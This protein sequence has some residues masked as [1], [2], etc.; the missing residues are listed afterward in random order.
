ML[1]GLDFIG[2]PIIYIITYV[3]LLSA[4][5]ILFLFLEH[6]RD[7]SAPIPKK[8]PKV[9]IIIPVYNGAKYIKDCLKSVKKLNYP[10]EKLEIVVVDD[11]STDNSYKEAKKFQ[12][13]KVLKKK[14]SGKAASV[15]HGLERAKGEIIG[16]LDCDSIVSKDALKKMVGYFNEKNVAAVVSGRKA[17][18][19][20]GLLE[21]FQEIEY[22]L[23]LFFWKNYSFVKGLFITPGVLSLYRKKVV[24]KIGKFQDNIT[25]DLEIALRIL[26]RD[27]SVK[28]ALEASTYT[29]VPHKFKDLTKQRVRWNYGLLSNLKNYSFLFSRKYKELGLFILP[30]TLLVN[31]LLVIFFTYIVVTF[32]FHWINNMYLIYLTGWE[33]YLIN[34]FNYQFKLNL[35]KSEFFIFMMMTII[36]AFT[37]MIYALSHLKVKIELRTLVKYFIYLVSAGYLY[38][39]FW[40]MTFYKFLRKD[41]KW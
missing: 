12:G 11:G 34:L 38:F 14:H 19:S 25:E 22:M 27:Y 17:K 5:Y 40:L 15:N 2:K 3:T 37:L 6:R 7:F 36:F 35:W 24:E 39:Y 30:L 4:I 41:I 21:K 8:F 16:V 33:T 10:K 26:S 13:V 31:L 18:N 1:P 9:S 28:C 29:Q 23:T 32:V 20:K